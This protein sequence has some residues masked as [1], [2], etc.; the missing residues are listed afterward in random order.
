MLVYVVPFFLLGIGYLLWRWRSPAFVI[1]LWIVA[2]A[3]INALL[4]DSAVYTRWIVVLPG[5]AV[6]VAVGLRYLLPVLLS[7]GE[8]SADDKPIL[9][10]RR[11]AVLL[12]G[13]VLVVKMVAQVNYYFNEHVPLLEKQ[14]RLAKPYGD[15]FD[16][17]LRSFDFPDA[18][19][20]YM[21]GDPLPDIN[22]PRSWIDLFTRSDRSTLRYFP[23]SPLQI[24]PAFIEQRPLNRN[25]ALFVDPSAHDAIALMQ[26]SFGCDM[27]HS[28]YPIDP[29]EKEFLLCFIPMPKAG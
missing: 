10:Y 24:T 20:I 8:R 6:V 22:V 18:T 19:D 1:V 2:T 14:V 3:G 28:P 13:A 29:P 26:A 25:L 27:Q 16:L 4:R 7:H 17:A 23:L 5:V 21:I 9:V 12:V 15:V 11:S